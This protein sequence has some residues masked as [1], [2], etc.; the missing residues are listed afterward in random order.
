[1]PISVTLVLTS[2][3]QGHLQCQCHFP[4]MPISGT[5]YTSMSVPLF[6]IFKCQQY[7]SLHVN[8][9]KPFPTLQSQCHICYCSVQSFTLKCGRL[10]VCDVCLSNT[11]LSCTPAPVRPACPISASQSIAAAGHCHG[12]EGSMDED[13]TRRR[14]LHN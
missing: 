1:M 3:Y 13:D 4:Y 7:I 11:G 12:D 2:Q 9:S 14:D 10:N 6:H 8:V 5:L